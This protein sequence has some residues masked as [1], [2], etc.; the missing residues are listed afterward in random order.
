MK[1]AKGL[2]SRY[3]KENIMTNIASTDNILINGTEIDRVTYYNHLGQTIATENRT[4]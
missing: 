3:I 1:K 4:T 2:V